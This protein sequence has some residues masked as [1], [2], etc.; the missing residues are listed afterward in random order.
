MIVYD[1][2]LVWYWEH[3]FDFATAIWDACNEHNI[4]LWSVSPENLVQATTELLAGR[5]SMR[6]LLDRAQYHSGF[7]PFL[8]KAETLGTYMINP[9]ERSNWTADKA[10]MHLE[11]ISQGLY[12]PY[13]L[14]LAPFVV[15]PVLP[16][17]D[18][19][20]LRKQFVVKPALGG[21]GEGVI[22]RATSPEEVLRARIEFAEQKYLLQ[23]RVEPQELEGR[24]A[25]FRVYYVDGHIYPCWWDPETHIFAPVRVDEEERFG[26]VPL[27]LMAAKIA[28]IC[29]LDW[30]STEIALSQDGKFI[31][32]DYVN[33][34]IDLRSQTQAHDGVPAEVLASIATDLVA[35]A[36]R[37]CQG[38]ES[39]Q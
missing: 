29:R 20:P 10:T 25:W 6:V 37:H 21:G 17:L 26:L 8:H 30:F 36:A 14:I 1:L 24:K 4:S 38:R 9:R 23:A 16:P 13:T 33:D 3:D 18:L 15:Q 2:C 39:G 11:M 22:Q 35:L 34:G 31:A 7:L 32:V 28:S 19:S 27:R 12:T 5:A